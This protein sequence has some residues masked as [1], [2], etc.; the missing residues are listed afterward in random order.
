M[1]PELPGDR[2]EGIEDF[3]GL[4]HLLC[5][6]QELQGLHVV[7]SVCH[8]YRDDPGIGR[9]YPRHHPAFLLPVEAIERHDLCHQLR[10][11]GAE[12][13]LQGG[14]RV[15]RGLHSVVQDRRAQGRIIDIMKPGQDPGDRYRMGDVR[16]T[17]VASLAL[18]IPGSGCGPSGAEIRA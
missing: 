16:I 2:H 12:V 15:R 17:A 9:P 11:L 7:Q 10:D 5:L 8:L 1:Q 6:R 13:P 18:M 4:A 3:P 14:Q